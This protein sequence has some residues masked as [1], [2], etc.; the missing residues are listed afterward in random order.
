MPLVMRIWGVDQPVQP[1]LFYSLSFFNSGR[2]LDKKTNKH[3]RTRSR[4]YTRFPPSRLY[5]FENANSD[6]NVAGPIALAIDVVV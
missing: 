3:K 5:S 6:V 2:R 1:H 4:T